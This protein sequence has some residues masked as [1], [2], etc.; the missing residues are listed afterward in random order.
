MMELYACMQAVMGNEWCGRCISQD[1]K[2]LFVGHGQTCAAITVCG[3]NTDVNS[4][5]GLLNSSPVASARMLIKQKVLVELDM[6]EVPQE[7]VVAAMVGDELRPMP[8]SRDM[9]SL[10]HALVSEC[11]SLNMTRAVVHFAGADFEFMYPGHAHVVSI[12]MNMSLDDSRKEISDGAKD[13]WW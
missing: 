13:R 6:F 1:K 9:Y 8:T 4:Y 5:Q 7:L 3:I 12:N 11:Y 2:A 10:I